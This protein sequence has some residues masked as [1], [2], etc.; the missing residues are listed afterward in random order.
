MYFHIY[1]IYILY[2]CGFV[3][4]LLVH[5]MIQMHVSG[6]GKLTF[7]HKKALNSW[8]KCYF[9]ISLLPGY[10]WRSADDT[11]LPDIFPR[12]CNEA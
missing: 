2:L 6:S 8:T 12:G 5:N 10:N 1:I 11:R 7:W 4:C 3:S 9:P